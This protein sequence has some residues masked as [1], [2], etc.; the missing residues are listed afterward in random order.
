MHIPSPRRRRLLGAASTLALGGTSL[1]PLAHHHEA[2]K[3]PATAPA[4]PVVAAVAVRAAPVARAVPHVASRGAT[5]RLPTGAMPVGD[6]RGWRQVLAQDFT[7]SR[8]PRGWGTYSGQP[9]GNPNGWWQPSHVALRGKD[10][11]LV[12]DWHDGRFVTGGLMSPMATTYGKYE[13]RFKVSRAP[14]VAYV[15]LLWP[16]DESWP[17]GGE[18]DFAEDGGGARRTTTATL[19]YGA[20]N[21]QV[22][23]HLRADF[24]R[25]QT[26]GVEW[27]PGRL[28]YTLNGRPWATVT[29]PRVPSR[30]M[31]LALQLEAGHGTS[32][33]PAPTRA[34]PRTVDMVVDW[35]V[36]YRRA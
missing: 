6:L 11:H 14:G 9:G 18:I 32:W 31:R 10:L 13:V 33:S 25:F 3:R 30:P 7:S 19:H 20:A 17:M 8:L 26:V 34:T 28:V 36:A 23:R 27:T 1:L 21:T 29:N 4:A 16:A 22:Q 5:R 2:H 15:L 12:G 35:V 24:S